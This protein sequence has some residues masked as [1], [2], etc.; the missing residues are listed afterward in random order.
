MLA[1]FRSLLRSWYLYLQEDQ[2]SIQIH[3]P[4][5]FLRWSVSQVSS[6][7]YA[8]AEKIHCKEYDF[9]DDLKCL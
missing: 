4:D 5:C 6:S 2:I 3:S 8:V 9:V 1:C 7:H